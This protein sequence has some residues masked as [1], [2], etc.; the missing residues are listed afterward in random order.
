MI[1]SLPILATA[2]LTNVVSSLPT[3]T[4]V[5]R[6]EGAPSWADVEEA[7]IHPGVNTDT[8]GGSCTSNFIY[9]NSAGD[10]FIG[11]AAHCSSRGEATETDGCSSDTYPE[12]TKVN[13]TGASVTGTMVYNSW[14]RMQSRGESDANSESG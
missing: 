9:Y 4:L 7:S 3:P 13:V 5:V 6:Q 8:Q 10:I 11:Q 1:L 12:G 2:L 14:A